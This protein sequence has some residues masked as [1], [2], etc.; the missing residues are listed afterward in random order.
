MFQ[1]SVNYEFLGIIGNLVRNHV[2]RYF[3]VL[4]WQ[5][6]PLQPRA[7]LLFFFFWP[8]DYAN[9]IYKLFI[10]FWS[11]KIHEHCLYW[12]VFSTNKYSKIFFN[13]LL[14]FQLYLLVVNWMS[15]VSKFYNFFLTCSETEEKFIFDGFKYCTLWKVNFQLSGTFLALFIWSVNCS[16]DFFSHFVSQ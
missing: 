4:H 5:K 2:W 12:K 1:W 16:R 6:L 11:L 9:L 13:S 3:W 8:I 15:W 10:T 7:T 14:L